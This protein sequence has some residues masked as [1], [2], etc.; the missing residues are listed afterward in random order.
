MLDQIALL[1]GLFAVPLIAL[2]LGNR[3]RD[4]TPSKRRFFW[5][6]VIGHTLGMTVTGRAAA[7]QQEVRN[8]A[9]A[10]AATVRRIRAGEMHRGDEGL[11]PPRPK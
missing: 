8:V 7:L 10:V 9:R 1:V 4:Q 3:F 2:K 5:G 6:A 11:A